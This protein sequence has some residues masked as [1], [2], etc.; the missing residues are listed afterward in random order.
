MG[1]FVVF[2]NLKLQPK[3]K[4]N[5]INMNESYWL[6]DGM[7]IFACPANQLITY[8]RKQVLKWPF[9]SVISLLLHV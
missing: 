1:L 3:P 2:Q 5:E 4:T 9:S 7:Q 6:Q 8:I